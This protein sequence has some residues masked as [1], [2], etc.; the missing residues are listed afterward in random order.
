MKLVNSKVLC[1]SKSGCLDVT[2]KCYCTQFPALCFA[3]SQ[4]V[5][6][7]PVSE[8]RGPNVK[9]EASFLEDYNFQQASPCIRGLRDPVLNRVTLVG[10]CLF[11][12]YVKKNQTMFSFLISCLLQLKIYNV[13]KRS[14]FFFN[15]TELIQPCRL[16]IEKCIN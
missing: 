14:F 9:H 1:F 13:D 16:K 6:P 2:V 4:A 5:M 3:V 10:L 7:S 8:H 11:I 12:C 15:Q